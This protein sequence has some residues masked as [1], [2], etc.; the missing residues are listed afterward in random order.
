MGYGRYI[1]YVGALAVALGV[2][3]AV[4]TTPG[5]A[6]ALPADTGS[7]SPTPGDTSPTD[8][9]PPSSSTTV[10]S[11]TTPPPSGTDSAGGAPNAK[12]GTDLR[13]LEPDLESRVAGALT[14]IFG[15]GDGAPVVV[16]RSSG[17][18]HTATK[19]DGNAKKPAITA[20]LPQSGKADAGLSPAKASSTLSQLLR[21]H[22]HPV[23][24]RPR[25]RS[26]RR[27]EGRTILP[28]FVPS[29]PTPSFA[30]ETAGPA[31]KSLATP[32][33]AG[34]P[35]P[36][37]D[38]GDVLEEPHTYL[39]GAVAQVAGAVL[40][41]F[42]APFG[43]GSPAQSPM[44]WTVLAFARNQFQRPIIPNAAS[45]QTTS[46]LNQS[47]NLLI[48]PGAETGDPSLSGYAAVTVPGWSQT[49]TPTVIEYGTQ[50]RFPVPTRIAGPVVPALLASRPDN[51]SPTTG[52][53]QQF[54]GG[55]PVA[56]S[57]L[58]QTVDLSGAA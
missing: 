27:P 57:T 28:S 26:F 53:G 31:M 18:A 36:R 39:V 6:Y 34:V 2:G 38:L 20:D 35:A 46:S 43:Q 3:A 32:P 54:F 14:K 15:G 16:V 50:R 1:G 56:D 55:G 40:N 10:A 44:L 47:P 11:L 12:G 9:S 37:P 25:H 23:A 19:D 17:G 33:T 48:N 7:E 52:G 29:A 13:L 22:A 51:A 41:V 30:A 8:T 58:T 49:G 45:G 4:A 21:P 42:L 24:R 5:I